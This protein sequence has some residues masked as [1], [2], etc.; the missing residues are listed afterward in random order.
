[1]DHQNLGHD[2]LLQQSTRVPAEH[3]CGDAIAPRRIAGADK[4]RRDSHRR[5]PEKKLELIES[6]NRAI[7]RN[8][9]P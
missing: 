8:A 1:M 4:T 2:S 6:G 9:L 5:A 7:L 3:V